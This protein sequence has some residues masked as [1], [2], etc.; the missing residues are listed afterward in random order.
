[1]RHDNPTEQ[2]HK[3]REAILLSILNLCRNTNKVHS[4][5]MK[6]VQV[7]M[8]SSMPSV[9][10]KIE[11]AAMFESFVGKKEEKGKEKNGT[12]LRVFF[13]K[14]GNFTS[15]ILILTCGESALSLIW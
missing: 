3:K 7:K 11:R 6:S 15:H 1:M 5:S 8:V 4:K 10:Q 2:V 14:K 9:T 13:K 12:W